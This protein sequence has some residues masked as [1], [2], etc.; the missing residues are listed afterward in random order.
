LENRAAKLEKIHNAVNKLKK[1]NKRLTSLSVP[2]MST[3]TPRSKEMIATNSVM[4][5]SI[6]IYPL[7]FNGTNKSYFDYTIVWS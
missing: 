2:L 6:S 4:A 5:E 1:K 3:T 7:I